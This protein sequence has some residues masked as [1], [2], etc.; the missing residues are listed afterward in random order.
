MVQP[1]IA[2]LITRESIIRNRGQMSLKNYLKILHSAIV[3]MFY[4]TRG[5]SGKTVEWGEGCYYVSYSSDYSALLPQL[6]SSDSTKPLGLPQ[7]VRHVCNI[8]IFALPL[9]SV[10]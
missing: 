4:K 7:N 10:C 5:V 8:L 2:H 9:P 3:E 1:E 6:A